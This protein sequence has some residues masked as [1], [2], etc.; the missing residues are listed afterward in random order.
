MKL[1]LFCEIASV[2]ACPVDMQQNASKTELIWFGSRTSLAKLYANERELRVDV[3]TTIHPATSVRDLA[4]L[5]D[6]EQCFFQLRRLQQ[7]RHKQW[8]MPPAGGCRQA[9]PLSCRA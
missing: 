8:R 7:V 9:A 4:I 5:I 2:G 1:E 3:D 6:S